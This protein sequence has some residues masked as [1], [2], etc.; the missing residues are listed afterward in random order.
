MESIKAKGYWVIASWLGYGNI[1]KLFDIYFI[2]TILYLLTLVYT[3]VIAN[4]Y[5]THTTGYASPLALCMDYL[6][7]ISQKP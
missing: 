6:I 1:N 2:L 7:K 5:W 4:L 3:L